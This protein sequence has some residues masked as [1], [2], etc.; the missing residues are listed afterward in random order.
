MSQPRRAYT[1]LAEEAVSAPRRGVGPVPT[2]IS[3]AKVG[4]AA[5]LAA[6]MAVTVM[7]TAQAGSNHVAADS[8]ALDTGVIEDARGGRDVSRDATR[9]RLP[10]SGSVSPNVDERSPRE[11]HQP[12]QP[13]LAA[14]GQLKAIGTRY[15]TANLK[16]RQVPTD[17]SK[18][19]ATLAVGQEI[20]ITA[21]TSG[22]YRQVIHQGKAAWVTAKYL[23]ATKPAAKPAGT[24]GGS[25]PAT[26][27]IT[28]N[29]TLAP[30]AAGSRVE[31]GLRANTIKLYRSVCATFPQIT[32]Y[33]GVRADSMPY[34]P[35]GRALDI[36][37]P[38]ISQNALG[39]QI[40]RW[41][42]ANASSFNVDHVIFDQQI[43]VKGMGWR[44]M[45][46]RGSATANHRDHVH[47]TVD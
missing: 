36:M 44:G 27:S 23:T 32:S 3:F 29:I 39:W 5:P 10:S 2:R 47:V 9:D 38:S 18:T 34:H 41:V 42:V 35:S 11:Q 28:G 15:S 14:T 4:I 17:Q 37:L 16:L 26:S 24:T 40:A 30:C 12:E 1:A 22:V 19:V 31:S 13:G 33:G 43:W 6:V 20:K 46:N 7:A 45:E 21:E 8:G 25:A